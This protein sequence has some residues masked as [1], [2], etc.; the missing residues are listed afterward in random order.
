MRTLPDIDTTEVS[1]SL[2]AFLQRVRTG[3][4][5]RILGIPDKREKAV[6]FQDLIDMGVV[7]E[8]KAREQAAK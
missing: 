7:P 8:A 2:A 1:G 4:E 6:T 3:W 5:R